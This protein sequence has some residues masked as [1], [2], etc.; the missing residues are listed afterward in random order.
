MPV[1][2]VALQV[3]DRATGTRQGGGGDGGAAL[4]HMNVYLSRFPACYFLALGGCIRFAIAQFLQHAD[5]AQQPPS[6]ATARRSST[7]VAPSPLRHHP[8]TAPPAPE[9]PPSPFARTARPPEYER[10]PYM[11]LAKVALLHVVLEAFALS[12][13]RPGALLARPACTDA[14]IAYHYLSFVSLYI[15]PVFAGA[16]TAAPSGAPQVGDEA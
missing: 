1:S 13:G 11:V 3:G 10:T 7:S 16:T 12:A 2:G 6:T 15:S 14:Y 8:S 9:P 5:L 4:P